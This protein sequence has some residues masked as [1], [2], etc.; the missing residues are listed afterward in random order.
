M[1]RVLLGAGQWLDEDREVKDLDP[2]RMTFPP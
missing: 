2:Y 1:M